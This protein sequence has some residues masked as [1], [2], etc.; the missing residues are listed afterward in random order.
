MLKMVK[1]NHKYMGN[2][3]KSNKSSKGIGV[4]IKEIRKKRLKPKSNAK[5]GQKKS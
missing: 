5:D 3:C 1:R 2:Y 4:G